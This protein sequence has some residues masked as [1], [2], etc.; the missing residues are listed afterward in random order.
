M[1]YGAIEG[2]GALAKTSDGRQ[3]LAILV[4]NSDRPSGPL[5]RFQGGQTRS[6]EELCTRA[7]EL[8]TKYGPLMI[9]KKMLVE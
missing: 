2:A 3:A 8:L 4:G 9:E 5:P 6:Q 7:Q 1:S